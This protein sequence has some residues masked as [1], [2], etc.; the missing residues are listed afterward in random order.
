[1][2]TFAEP[3]DMNGAMVTRYKSMSLIIYTYCYTYPHTHPLT[4]THTHTHMHTHTH[5][6]TQTHT[7]EWCCSDKF[8]PIIG[9]FVMTDLRKMEYTIPDLDKP[10]RYYV[11]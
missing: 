2:V 7:V 1:M 11:L 5:T 6:H 9:D 4:H 10:V 3:K 8:T